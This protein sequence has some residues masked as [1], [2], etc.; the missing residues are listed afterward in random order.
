MIFSNLIS[1]ALR[2]A[3][4]ALATR[5]SSAWR[6]NRLRAAPHR[7]V[8]GGGYDGPKIHIISATRLNQ[9]EF[10]ERTPL[11]KSLPSLEQLFPMGRAITYEN[12]A[13]LPKVYNT[14]LDR[15]PDSDIAVFVHDDVLIYDYFL[16]HRLVDGLAHFDVIGV[17]G[18]IQAATDHVSWYFRMPEGKQTLVTIDQINAS[19]AVRHL[20]PTGEVFSVFGATPQ[21]VAL[22]DGLF[23]AARVGT[24]RRADA[25]FDERFG[26]HFYDVDFC[27]TCLSKGLTI[28][29][30]P[31]A[32]GHGSGG[33]FTSPAWFEGLAAYR[34]K[35]GATEVRY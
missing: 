1:E 2:D 34:K 15:L 21:R 32:L 33:N 5:L 22:L 24:L 35:W 12:L 10:G 9:K 26:F 30:W 3:G 28:G 8:G 4:A 29:T 25:R 7:A 19:G 11:A 23:I 31:I 20:L 13:G 27:R 14:T 18:S 16:P 17:A 6:A